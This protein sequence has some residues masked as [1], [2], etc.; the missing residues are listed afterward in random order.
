VCLAVLALGTSAGALAQIRLPDFGD[1]SE[2]VF[3]PAAK[4]RRRCTS[5]RRTSACEPV[6]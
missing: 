1:S 5:S 3:N 2:A 6:R 4:S